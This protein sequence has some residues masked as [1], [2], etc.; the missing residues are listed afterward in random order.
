MIVKFPKGSSHGLYSKEKNTKEKRWIPYNDDE[1]IE[2]EVEVDIQKERV[3]NF[4]TKLYDKDGYIIF[5]IKN[6]SQLNKLV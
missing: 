5:L 6:K 4:L 1:S 2:I 3:Y